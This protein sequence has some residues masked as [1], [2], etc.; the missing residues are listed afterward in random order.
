MTDVKCER[1]G[2]KSFRYARKLEASYCLKCGKEIS[3]KEFEA[4]QQDNEK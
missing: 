3:P 1:C 4:A 2:S